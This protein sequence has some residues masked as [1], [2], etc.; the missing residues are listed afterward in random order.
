MKGRRTLSWWWVGDF[1]W[2]QR[3]CPQE[4]S[5]SSSSLFCSEVGLGELLQDCQ[6]VHSQPLSAVLPSQKARSGLSPSLSWKEKSGSH[7]S[8]LPPAKIALGCW[9]PR[10]PMVD[11]E[12]THQCIGLADTRRWKCAGEG[13]SQAAGSGRARGKRQ[14]IV[15]RSELFLRG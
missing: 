13:G 3:L 4:F 10:F 11:R 14:I 15:Q 5:L 9:E 1:S 8:E 12:Q 2:R 7:F 6:P